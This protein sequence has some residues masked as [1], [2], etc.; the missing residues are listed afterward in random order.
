MLVTMLRKEFPH[1]F[2]GASSEEFAVAIGS[3]DYPHVKL[4][5]LP[6]A[7]G[8]APVL[9]FGSVFREET[10]YPNM[11]A[12]PM[13]GTHL[14]CFV[15]WSQFQRVCGG[16]RTMRGKGPNSGWHGHGQ[17]VFG[18]EFSLD[19]DALIPQVIWRGTD[20]GYLP[21]LARPK[22]TQPLG[23]HI[24]SLVIER[25][26]RGESKEDKMM[27]ATQALR[28]NYELLLPRWKG[29]VIS[30][31]AELEVTKGKRDL[32]WADM[33][34][35]RSMHNGI[36]PFTLGS[37]KY[38]TYDEV[39]IATGQFLGSL[40]TAKYKYQIDLGGGGGTTW[41]GTLAK[42]S[43]PGLLFH[44]ITP[45]K[46][47]IHDRL[48]PWKHYIPVAPDLRD[49]REKFDWAEHHPKQAKRIADQSTQLMR[50]LGTEEGFGEMYQE[51]FVEPLRR[52]I[53]AYQPLSTTHP[54]SSWRDILESLPEGSKMKP[55]G[56]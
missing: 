18:E 19:W 23:E 42:L 16:F 2:Q 14:Q 53:E 6:H 20:F 33:K 48:K 10:V 24:E 11:V 39:G 49:L 34:L 46:D 26:L 54:E 52:I 32:A 51:A 7:T 8:V 30:A 9:M 27:E 28:E 1:R 45:T 50:H 25:K 41:L 15:V 55:R 38:L 13:P 4:K 56:M 35:S 5:N 3:G 43:M 47:Y 31:E 12:M 22:K 36:F 37:K 17:L 21:L 44:H 40:E 29:C